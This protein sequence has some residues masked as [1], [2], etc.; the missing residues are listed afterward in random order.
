M[1]QWNKLIERILEGDVGMDHPDAL[2]AA[3]DPAFLE[4]LDETRML[5]GR[6]DEDAILEELR[7]EGPKHDTLGISELVQ[8]GAAERNQS[9]RVGRRWFMIAAAAAAALVLATPFLTDPAPNADPIMLGGEGFK[10]LTPEDDDSDFSLF[11]WTSAGRGGSYRVVVFDDQ[12]VP[13]EG[14]DSGK[15]GDV[16]E[17]PISPAQL[18]ALERAA[19]WQVTWTPP[20]GGRAEIAFMSATP[21][22]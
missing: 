12:G 13:L 14:G 10:A 2:E 15:L 6:L 11:T 4:Q 3:G 7:S 5:L 16:L 21:K 9:P 1:G 19:A 18:K 20:G 17:W 8:Q 22:L